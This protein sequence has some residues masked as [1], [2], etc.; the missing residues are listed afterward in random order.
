MEKKI[1]KERKNQVFKE[2]AYA[3]TLFKKANQKFFSFQ[4]YGLK[5]HLRGF[6]VVTTKEYK[7]LDGR[8]ERLIMR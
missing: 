8:E 3:N 7:Y 1:E 4:K 5:I 2:L 6:V